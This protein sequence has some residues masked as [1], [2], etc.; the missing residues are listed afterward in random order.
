MFDLVYS[1]DL[2]LAPPAPGAANTLLFNGSRRI[3]VLATQSLGTG[4][5][6]STTLYTVTSLDGIGASPSV[7]AVFAIAGTPQ[8]VELAVSADLVPGGL[9]QVAFAA[10]PFANGTTFT[11]NLTGRLAL[12][13]NTPNAQ[14]E[15]S[16]GDFDL[17]FYGRDLLL[18]DNGD[19]ALDATGDLA[20]I[21]GRQNWQD[22]IERRVMSDGIPWDA[23]YGAKPSDYVNAPSQ[24]QLP[25]SARIVQQARADDRTLTAQVQLVPNPAGIKGA[26]AFQLSAQG[27]DGLSPITVTTPLPAKTG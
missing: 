11:G 2:P 16:T 14:A 6:T 1:N 27:R 19:F 26:Y 5:F 9:Y 20:T 8:A 10:M 4:A 25:L 12:P 3:R 22:A 23:A 18:G 21:S 17:L 13:S 7:N 24:Y 15:P